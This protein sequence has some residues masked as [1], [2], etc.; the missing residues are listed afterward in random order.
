[1][2]SNRLLARLSRAD[3]NLL[4]RDFEPIELRDRQQLHPRNRPIDHVNFLESGIASVVANGEHALEIGIIGRD[5][6]TGVALVFGSNE[7]PHHDTYIQIAG[8]GHRLSADHLREALDASATLRN[9][10]LQYAHAFMTQMADTALANGRHKIEERLARWLLLADDRLDDHEI[11]LTHE[12]LGVM[13]GTARPGVTIALQELERRG[14]ITHKRGVVTIIDR[15]GLIR[16]SNGAYVPP[17]D[18]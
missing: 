13:L 18:T 12:Y 8:K 1:V 6:M 15:P 2:S 14:W 5:G 3:L 10:L 9:V 4:E 16:S 17:N 7:P 11:P